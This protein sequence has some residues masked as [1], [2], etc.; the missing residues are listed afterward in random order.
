MQR[1]EKELCTLTT[2]FCRLGFYWATL[3]H[4]SF[5]RAKLCRLRKFK[6]GWH[7]WGRAC[8]LIPPSQLSQ[9]LTL[10]AQTI[11]CLALSNALGISHSTWYTVTFTKWMLILC[12]FSFPCNARQTRPSDVG[13]SSVHWLAIVDPSFLYLELKLRNQQFLLIAFLEMIC[14][15]LSL[16]IT[17]QFLFII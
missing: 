11:C 14:V 7:L 9:L 10:A 13:T 16:L 5:C 3:M 2:E 8:Q 15:T 6:L 12:A 17:K 4:V 1:D